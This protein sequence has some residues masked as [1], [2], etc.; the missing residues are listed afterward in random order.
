MPE[1]NNVN[2]CLSH[3]ITKFCLNKAQTV[4][5]AQKNADSNTGDEYTLT[6]MDETNELLNSHEACIENFKLK[7]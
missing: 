4:L 6:E 5:N 7:W 1:V 3:S 2:P